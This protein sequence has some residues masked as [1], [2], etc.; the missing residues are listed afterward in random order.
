MNFFIRCARLSC[1]FSVENRQD[2]LFPNE[3]HSMGLKMPYGFK[4]EAEIANELHI[5]SCQLQSELVQKNIGQSSRL[6]LPCWIVLS[7]FLDLIRTP[8]PLSSR[9]L[10]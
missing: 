9:L 3:G 7:N 5:Q 6:M 1:L 8:D 2:G 10:S 4:T